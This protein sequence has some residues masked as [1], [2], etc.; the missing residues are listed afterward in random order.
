MNKV[1]I[2][3]VGLFV[4]CLLAFSVRGYAGERVIY[5]DNFTSLENWEG[6]SRVIKVKENELISSHGVWGA[7]LNKEIPADVMVECKMKVGDKKK[8]CQAGIIHLRWNKKDDVQSAYRVEIRPKSYIIIHYYATSSTGYLPRKKVLEKKYE[9]WYERIH[10]WAYSHFPDKKNG[11]WYKYLHRD[12][13]ISSTVKGNRWGGPFHL[14][15]MQLYCWK[16]LEEMKK[17]T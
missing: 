6:G 2:V 1:R 4:I 12:G 10:E 15:Q 11:E 3:S 16:L 7:M 17:E 5:I 13:T 9:E 14:P 8:S